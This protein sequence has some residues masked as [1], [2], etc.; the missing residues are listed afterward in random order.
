MGVTDEPEPLNWPAITRERWAE[1]VASDLG[2]TD[3][4]VEL[5]RT[6]PSGVR[7]SVLYTDHVRAPALPENLRPRRGWKASESF[8]VSVGRVS[9]VVREAVLE[10]LTSVRLAGDVEAMDREEF[11]SLLA[12]LGAT[13]IDRPQLVLRPQSIPGAV[14]DVVD[15]LA[16]ELY[17]GFDPVRTVLADGH[18]GFDA[19]AVAEQE[20]ALL[21]RWK[22]T[23]QSGRAFEVD[24]SYVREAGANAVDELAFLLA[25]T[26]ERLR[27][28][29]RAGLGARQWLKEVTVRVGIG[30]DL[31]DEIAKLRAVRLLYAKLCQAASEGDCGLVAPVVH[32]VSLE[33]DLAP[34]DRASN[35]LRTSSQAFVGAVGGADTIELAPFERGSRIGER[36]ARTTHSVLIHEAHLARVDDPAGGSWYVEA[37]TDAIARAAWNRFREIERAGGLARWIE[38]G[39]LVALLEQRRAELAAA[40]DSGA[41]TIVGVTEYPP[42]AEPADAG[43]NASRFGGTNDQPWLS[44]GESGWPRLGVLCTASLAVTSG[45]GKGGDGNGGVAATNTAEVRS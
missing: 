28:A 38:A 31:F 6:A 16:L 30:R 12:A 40:V 29:T 24:A 2:V 36:L 27:G 21:E 10:G 20:V 26:T 45:D 9:S 23:G 25:A 33:C 11:E 5:A 43:S 19:T 14:L 37:M 3:A 22:A 7:S 34:V 41:H 32:A 1:R 44:V 15:G 42:P 8:D 35:A 4:D 17:G 13:K 18:G 39:A